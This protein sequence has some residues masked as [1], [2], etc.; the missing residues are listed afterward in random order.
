[1]TPIQQLMLGVGG[2]KKSYIDDL[3]STYVYDGT[4]SSLS[5]NNGIDVSGEGGLVWLKSRSTT[6]AHKLSDTIRGTTKQLSSNADSAQST[7]SDFITGFTSTGFTLGT[8]NDINHSSQTYSSW[9]FRR[10]PGFFDV[11]SWTGN[12]NSNRAISHALE[13]KPGFIAV[14]N[15]S[16]SANWRCYH[17]SANNSATPYTNNI[18]L[19]TTDSISGLANCFDAAP[20]STTFTVGSHDNVNGNGNEYIAYVFAG[21]EQTGKGSVKFDGSSGI[22]TDSTS[23]YTIGTGEFTL[24]FWVQ[25]YNRTSPNTVQVVV[26]Q[27]DGSTDAHT[28]IAKNSNN[29]IY[30]ERGPGGDLVTSTT[31]ILEN[32][33]YH[34]AVTRNSSNRLSIWIDG[35]EEAYMTSS[36]SWG[37]TRFDFGGAVHQTGWGSSTYISNFRFTKGQCLYTSSF[38]PSTTPLTLT[39]QGA[40]ASNVKLLCFNDPDWRST[41]KQITTQELTRWNADKI[42]GSNISPFTARINADAIHG[43]GKDQSLMKCGAYYG[44]GSADGIKITL[45]WEPQWILIKDT[46]ATED[47]YL[48]DSIRCISQGRSNDAALMPSDDYAENS[49]GWIEVTGDGVQITTAAGS[50]NSNGNRHIYIAIRRPDGYVG[51]PAKVGTDVFAIGAGQNSA[52]G[53]IAGFPVDWTMSR[54]PDSGGAMYTGSRMQGEYALGTH[55][56]SAEFA[57]S[58]RVFDFNNGWNIS[59]GANSPELAW[60]W[61]RHAGFDLVEFKSKG[62]SGTS[63]AHSLGKVPEMMW[64]KNKTRASTDW[65]VYHKDLHSSNPEKY[66]LKLNTDGMIQGPVDDYFNYTGGGGG[67]GITATHANGG[68]FHQTGGSAGDNVQVLLFASVSGISKVGGYS[69]SASAQTISCG[70]QPRFVII[71]RVNGSND[72]WFVFDTTRGWGSGN[73]EALEL[74][75]TDVQFSSTDFGA[76]TSTGFSLTGDVPKVNGSGNDYIYY[77]HA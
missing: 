32:T 10:A 41:T 35:D 7:S 45:G 64:F 54:D 56:N 31:E 38:T 53:F 57:T 75:S 15:L 70:F 30:V 66:H 74:D 29:R 60:M 59:R 43:D 2:A 12:G 69:G 44:N 24:E 50:F 34:V 28:I 51:K 63:F 17:C 52:P 5:I 6:Y 19:N 18:R 73:D 20:T 11:V 40:T 49:G 16:G 68:G 14:K 4:G 72:H 21:G 71:K 8:D 46:G 39:S 65:F 1:M 36:N 33:W 9:T 42:E 22:R 62:G 37:G 3:F 67:T 55:D 26:D 25:W 13:A 48:F 27:R 58:S 76:P 77:A 23:D 61:K 47:W